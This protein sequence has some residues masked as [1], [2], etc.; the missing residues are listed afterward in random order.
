ML[1]K[2][3]SKFFVTNIGKENTYSQGTDSISSFLNNH[4]Q[5]HL[6]STPIII[7]KTLF[8]S[9]NTLIGMVEFH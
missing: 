2:K 5:E 8:W 1:V 9:K 4:L 6:A 3:L 7:L